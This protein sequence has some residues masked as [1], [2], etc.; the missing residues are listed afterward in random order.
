M[1]TIKFRGK[2]NGTWMHSTPD[3]DDWEQFWALVDKSTVGQWTGRK[4][5]NDIEIYEDDIVEATLKV[6]PFHDDREVIE[7]VYWDDE[8]AAF[9]PFHHHVDFPE[10]RW[11]DIA[12]NIKVIGNTRDNESLLEEKQ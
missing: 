3:D 10:D 12:V 8:K 1:R 11:I 7:K 5:R 9:G 6:Y 4:D 2:F